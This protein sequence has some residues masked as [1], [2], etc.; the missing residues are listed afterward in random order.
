MI[1]K[2]Q[3]EELY[4]KQ[5]KLRREIAEELN[6]LISQVDFYLNKYHIKKIVEKLEKVCPICDKHFFVLPM[7]KEQKYCCMACSRIGTRKVER[8]ICPNCGKEFP[9]YYR[10]STYCS[11]KCAKEHKTK[12]ND[13]IHI[14]ICQECGKK[15]E[16]F[17]NMPNWFKE[18]QHESNKYHGIDSSKYCCYDC[19][20]KHRQKVSR[21]TC[22]EK[23]GKEF[24]GQTENNLNKSC[25]TKLKKYG[26]AHYTGENKIGKGKI[27][28]KKC[29]LDEEKIYNLL[30]TKFKNTKFNKYIKNYG[31]CDFYIPELNLY[32][33]Y[34]GYWTHG[35]NGS[36]ILGPYDKS[37]EKHK[38][39]LKN[40]KEKADKGFLEYFNA[41][42]TWTISD[43][44]RRDFAKNNN[45]NWIEFFN[46]IEFMN[47]F[48]KQ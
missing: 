35:K 8:K 36:E 15:Y 21:K 32:I 33:E 37:D 47:W 1:A 43:P 7:F 23:Y 34:Q 5:N 48:E 16:H 31:K 30:I 11:R 19:G 29:S 45:L 28:N 41:I 22:L 10:N 9:A 26:D 2:E 42:K 27:N 24:T 6:V 14:N 4:I 40:W 12:L 38:N 13:E 25:E 44:K 18:G 17:N 20:V 39:L 3:L 46:M